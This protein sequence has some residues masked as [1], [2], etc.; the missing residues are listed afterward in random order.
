MKL[1][2]QVQKL[3]QENETLKYKLNF[4][5]TILI[6][7][8]IKNRIIS[9]DTLMEREL[10]WIEQGDIIISQK[11]ELELIINNESL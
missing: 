5:K 9:T 1:S 6:R 10:Q 8:Y 7:L 2:H 3:E 11:N 4:M